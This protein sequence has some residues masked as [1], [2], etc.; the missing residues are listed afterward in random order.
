MRIHLPKFAVFFV[1]TAIAQTALAARVLLSPADVKRDDATVVT[2]EI[3]D[4][5]PQTRET[6][7]K[8]GSEYTYHGYSFTL[9][10][11]EVLRGK[12][13]KTLAIAWSQQGYA[14]NWEFDHRPKD[15]MKVVAY[16]DPE[17]E[18]GKPALYFHPNATEDLETFDDDA[19]VGLRR[20]FAVWKLDS[21]DAQVAAAKQGCFDDNARFQQWCIGALT[22]SYRWHDD[23]AIAQRADPGEIHMLIQRVFADK[24]TNFESRMLCDAYLCGRDERFKASAPRYDVFAR[25]LRKF[26]ELNNVD[27]HNR[28]NVACD[29]LTQFPRRAET[30]FTLLRELADRPQLTHRWTILIHSRNLYGLGTPAMDAALVDYLSEKLAGDGESADGAAIAIA[31]IAIAAAKAGRSVPDEIARLLE[32]RDLRVKDQHALGRLEAGRK[33]VARIMAEKS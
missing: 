29:V 27:N 18:A 24:G 30:T 11:H 13:D 28:V 5:K 23:G 15:G 19:V 26:A 1:L 10:V 21:L 16:L 31:Q 33:D 9:R 7:L 17:A 14:A 22:A 32:N 3:H 12:A 4:V 2:A 8:D 6:K 20:I 25:E